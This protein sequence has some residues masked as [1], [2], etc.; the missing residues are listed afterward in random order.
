MII[1]IFFQFQNCR[2]N[3]EQNLPSIYDE[4]MNTSDF[5]DL[6]I[7]PIHSHPPSYIERYTTISKPSSLEIDRSCGASPPYLNDRGDGQYSRSN[8]SDL[9]KGTSR[10]SHLNQVGDSNEQYLRSSSSDS[11]NHTSSSPLNQIEDIDGHHSRSSPC[12]SS[13]SRSSA[14]LNQNQNDDGQQ[15]RSS[16]SDSAIYISDS[17]FIQSGDSDGRRSRSSPSDSVIS[18]SSDTTNYLQ[19]L[20]QLTNYIERDSV[21]SLSLLSDNEMSNAS[22]VSDSSSVGGGSPRFPKEGNF[23]TLENLLIEYPENFLSNFMKQPILPSENQ[24]LL[25]TKDSKL[26][27]DE[28]STQKQTSKLPE[29]LQLADQE[30]NLLPSYTESTAKQHNNFNN[31]QRKSPNFSRSPVSNGIPG[32]E[33]ILHN[34]GSPSSDITTVDASELGITC[35]TI[36]K[37]QRHSNMPVSQSHVLFPTDKR[38]PPNEMTQHYCTSQNIPNSEPIQSMTNIPY[39]T[40]NSNVVASSSNIQAN[41]NPIISNSCAPLQIP[42]TYSKHFQPQSKIPMSFH[43]YS[44][45]VHSSHFNYEQF[46]GRP[47]TSYQSSNSSSINC[48]TTVPSKCVQTIST[49]SNSGMP[50]QIPAIYPSSIQPGK[51]FE[52]KLTF[53]SPNNSFQVINPMNQFLPQSSRH[54]V[55]HPE[56]NKSSSGMYYVCTQNKTSQNSVDAHSSNVTCNLES[57]IQELPNPGK[58]LINQ[59]ICS[60]IFQ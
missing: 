49:S 42:A 13:I 31:K 27:S 24:Q 35:N 48:T 46:L 25:R 41:I 3:E 11:A 60:N 30:N 2:S 14:H 7:M 58:R 37:K 32:S 34:L 20:A 40:L 54:P 6:K 12:G 4:E 39:Q 33:S 50:L 8:Q 28:E 29:D 22:S 51:M 38:I 52:D 18:T 1:Y 19:K 57:A 44:A 53:Q 36:S 9:A 16:P 56:A 59:V 45:P 17:H 10:S 47:D 21:K 43:Q 26:A 15:S 5:P 55:L 23:Q